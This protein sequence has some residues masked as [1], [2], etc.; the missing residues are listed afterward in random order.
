MYAVNESADAR[1]LKATLQ[2]FDAASKAIGKETKTVK[3]GYREVVPVFDLKRYD[4][5]SHFVALALADGDKPVTDNFYVLPAKDNEYNWKK[6][7]WYITPIT[8]Y[9]DLGFAFK[10]P[11]ADVEMTYEH[12]QGEGRRRQPRRPLHLERQFLPD[13]PRR[14]QGRHL[15]V[16]DEGI[17]HRTG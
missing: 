4:G 10:Q 5:K 9:A 1:E 14:D 8:A 11:K 3:V 2:V 15:P 12:P 6:T 16:A 13:P 7:N 17:P